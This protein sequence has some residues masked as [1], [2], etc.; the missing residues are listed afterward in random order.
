MARESPLF[1]MRF[2]VVDNPE[3][4]YIIV[5]IIDLIEFMFRLYKKGIIDTQIWYRW[6][7]Y[8]RGMKTIPKFKRV[9]EKISGV[10][11]NE[12]REF[13]DKL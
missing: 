8:M 7:G 2:S 4:Y 10:H 13:V 1:Q 9:W 11:A 5:A 12:F 6:E 3:E